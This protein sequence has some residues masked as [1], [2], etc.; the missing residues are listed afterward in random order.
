MVGGD[1]IG[2][3]GAGGAPGGD[4]DEACSAAGIDKVKARLK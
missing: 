1:V 4:K 2:A 3:V